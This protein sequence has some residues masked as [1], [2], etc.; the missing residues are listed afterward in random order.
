MLPSDMQKFNEIARSIGQYLGKTE[1]VTTALRD[2]KQSV[3]LLVNSNFQAI[4]AGQAAIQ[5]EIKILHERL[6]QMG[7]Q[8]VDVYERSWMKIKEQLYG[9]QW[10]IAVSDRILDQSDYG[11]LCRAHDILDLVVIEWLARLNFL[12]FGCGKGHISKAAVERKTKLSVG[13][14]PQVT[15][16]EGTGYFLTNDFKKVEDAGPYDVV[17]L[18][19]V[20]DHIVG[21]TEIEALA[22]V[23]NLLSSIGKV[24]LRAHPWSSI[25]GGHLYNK[26]NK[27]YAHLV[28]D[29]V[30][31]TRLGGYQSDEPTAR[32]TKPLETYR[33]WLQQ[34]G[35]EIKIEYPVIDPVPDFFTLPQNVVVRDRLKKHWGEEDPYPHM[36]IRYVDYVLVSKESNHKIF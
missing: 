36:S 6:D 1:D 22:K 35:F 5:E 3:D 31:L 12:D 11:L 28:F 20:L 34:A 32:I 27:A 10:P 21:E 4:L 24:Y 9:D 18:Y 29:D 23:K 15:A 17:L 2:A 19:D 16:E 13:Y 30:E 33:H 14:D 25:S 8:K 26:L 7:V